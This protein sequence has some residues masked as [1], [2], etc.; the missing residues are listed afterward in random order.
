MLVDIVYHAVKDYRILKGNAGMLYA[1]DDHRTLCNKSGFDSGLEELEDFF[2]SDW[3]QR[4]CD[5]FDD[6]T[7]D[8]ILDEIL[9]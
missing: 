4:I 9:E 6:L 2:E 3:F 7:A 8:Q 1:D 5:E